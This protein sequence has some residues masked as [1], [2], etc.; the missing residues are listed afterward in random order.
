MKNLIRLFVLLCMMTTSL[1]MF[2][3]ESADKLYLE[4]QRLQK[5]MTIASQD[6]AIA[7]FKSAKAIYKVATKKTMCDNQIAVCSNNKQTIKSKSYGGG[8]SA[9]SANTN[10]STIGKTEPTPEKVTKK[11]VIM[12]LSTER[13]DFKYKPKKGATQSVDVTGDCEGWKISKKPDWVIVSI[14]T[15]K[16]YVEAQENETG[17]ERSG[18]ITVSCE[19]KSIDVVVNQ[20]KPKKINKLINKVF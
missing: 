8:K 1:C 12:N 18:V 20:E 17:S 2:A 16:F 3:Q 7:K 4:G 10:K 5:T 14:T 19:D 13:L 6:Q 15:G 9:S 11:N